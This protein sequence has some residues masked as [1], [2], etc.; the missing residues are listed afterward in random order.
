MLTLASRCAIIS[1]TLIHGCWKKRKKDVDNF[2]NYCKINS[3]F[4]NNQELK[5]YNLY[6]SAILV[7]SIS[8]NTLTGALAAAL[9]I[10]NP[11]RMASTDGAF[12][13]FG[14][15]AYELINADELK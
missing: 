2:L 14:D 1:H 9:E 8:A 4:K 3:Y 13:W 6:K 10:N 5:M 15:S 11:T 7:R 12:Q